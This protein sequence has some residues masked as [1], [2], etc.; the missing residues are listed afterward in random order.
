MSYASAFSP[1]Y[2]AARYRFC[3]AAQALGFQLETYP[4]NQVGPDGEDL[5]IDVAILGDLQPEQILV[6]S[7]GLHGVEGFFGSAVQCALLEERLIGWCPNPGSALVL[8]HA[9]NPYGFAWGRRWNEDNIDLNRNFLLENE[10]YRG[11]PPMYGQLN[12]FFNPTSPPSS[13][14]PF[15]MKAI[16]TIFRY[17]IDALINTLPVGQFDYPQGLFFGGHRPSQTYEILAAHLPRWIGN[18]KNILHIDLHTG[19]GKKAT[20]KLFIEDPPESAS[21][22]WLKQQ[23]GADVVEP[24]QPGKMYKIRGS[25]G[26]WCKAMFPQCQY[27]FLTAEF[28]T[29]PVIQ[30]VQA[31]RA[32]NCAYFY[33]PPDHP[34]REW[35]RQR[36]QEVF[37]PADVAWRNAVVSQGLDLI[38]QAI[39]VCFPIEVI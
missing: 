15:L 24:Y 18:A 9:L 23:F 8:I 28:G 35:A 19:L 30:V 4:I 13:F 16:A 22:R 12:G 25:L 32:E 29:Y 36:L 3:A 26:N 11:S 39:E 38:E 33:T 2:A 27:R 1:S 34:T 5:T 17:G 20:Y 10:E 37:A 7:S 21:T 14:E 6:I 31:L